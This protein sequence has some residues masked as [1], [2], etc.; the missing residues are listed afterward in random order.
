MTPEYKKLQDE[1]ET[2]IQKDIASE[3]DYQLLKRHEKLAEMKAVIIGFEQEEIEKL[4]ASLVDKKAF[5]QALAMASSPEVVEATFVD[6]PTVE[7]MKRIEA[8]YPGIMT[9]DESKLA[10]RE[11]S[12]EPWYEDFQEAIRRQ[13]RKDVLAVLEAKAAEV[14]N[15]LE[16][17]GAY[18]KLVAAVESGAARTAA[19]EI[20]DPA[21]RHEIESAL[22]NGDAGMTGKAGKLEAA[23]MDEALSELDAAIDAAL[24]AQ[25]PQPKEAHESFDDLKAFGED[26]TVPAEPKA[27][28]R[29][30]TK[31]RLQRW[32][33]RTEEEF[34]SYIDGNLNQIMSEA[35]EP[36]D[37]VARL[38]DGPVRGIWKAMH[39]NGLVQSATPEGE[40]EA[41]LSAHA[42]GM[43]PEAKAT[44]AQGAQGLIEKNLGAVR[45]SVENAV[46]EAIARKRKQLA[47]DPEALQRLDV[48]EKAAAERK[49]A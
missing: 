4:A 27:A 11:W 18:E 12:A 38:I 47:A 14:G 36:H 44:M 8:A 42:A 9:T 10:K 48:I 43:T 40:L 32:G 34:A 41:I 15:D 6:G 39:D 31:N 16:A 13:V 28:D 19:A 46:R 30:R 23:A 5:A 3:H 26:V 35:G 17:V 22:E 20:D 2:S 45:E 29:M 33:D 24:T 25:E 21:L 7:V 49:A 1:N 37:V